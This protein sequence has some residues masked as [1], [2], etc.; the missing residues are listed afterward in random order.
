MK[1]SEYTLGIWN[2]YFVIKIVLFLNGII[3]FNFLRNFALL[4]FLLIPIKS[5][6]FLFIQQ[7]IA[8]PLAI[9]VLY[10][11]SYLPPLN[12]ALSQSSHISQFDTGYL[13]ELATRFF[14][15]NFLL[16]TFICTAL[17]FMLYNVLRVTS[18]VITALFILFISQN[19]NE[20][21]K[22]DNSTNLVQ[23][24]NPNQS[25]ESPSSFNNS[26]FKDQLIHYQKDFFEKQSTLQLNLKSDAAS[27]IEFDILVLS[28]CSLAW[29]DINYYHLENHKLL[30]EFDILFE[31][32]N[33]ATSYSGPA[34]VR[35]LQANCGQ[36]SHN[37]IMSQVSNKQCYLA[38]NLRNLGYDFEFLLNHDGKFDDFASLVVEKGDLQVTPNHFNL[39]PYLLNFDN[40]YIHRDSDMFSL[41]LQNRATNKHNKKFTLYNTVS[42]HDGVHFQYKKS[43]N[44]SETY[45]ERLV[46]LLDDFYNILDELKKANKP[47]VVLMVPEHGANI[48]GDKVQISGMRE[49]PSPKITNVP[50]GLKVI[51]NDIERSGNQIRVKEPASF[52]AIGHLVNQ[53]LAQDVFNK[54]E[55]TPEQLLTDIPSTPLLSENEGSIVMK[56]NNDFYYSFN[57]NE[58]LKYQTEQ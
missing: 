46:N 50:V 19:G 42:L 12:R 49:L 29:D 20:L 45:K 54:R 2:I 7:L 26:S 43:I 14:S 15:V 21:N 34:V 55:F 4:V 11:D 33:S 44:A 57:N 48:R 5:R 25:V 28:I 39:K 58:W 16:I 47:I 8:L 30:K 18:L 53:L 23:S 13:F 52:L 56:Y 10:D 1:S 40:S 37:S 22:I 32:F 31:N 51:G 27:K 35:L 38:N 3:E 9:F 6:S 17:Y 41:W 24:N 36:K